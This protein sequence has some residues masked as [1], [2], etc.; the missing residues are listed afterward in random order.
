LVLLSQ[1]V[2][3]AMGKEDFGCLGMGVENSSMTIGVEVPTLL[4]ALTSHKIKQLSAGGWHSLFVTE[5]GTMYSSGK[6]EYGRLGLG[7]ETAKLEP[8][9]VHNTFEG[10]AVE[11]IT[12]ASAGGSHTIWRDSKQRVF[13]VGRLD[14]GRCGLGPTTSDRAQL[15]HDISRFIYPGIGDPTSSASSPIARE[16]VQVSAGGAHSLI[17]VDYTGVDD[18]EKLQVALLLGAYEF[19]S[20]LL[21]AANVATTVIKI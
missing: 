17:V 5:E 16:I 2:V 11:G 1:K 9:L 12:Q 4:Q 10:N 21:Q 18:S 20:K 6:G 3:Y 7:G 14:G 19:Q 15:A 13:V 8:S